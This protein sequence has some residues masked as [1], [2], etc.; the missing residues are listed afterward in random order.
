MNKTKENKGEMK[1]MRKRG[2]R[3]ESNTHTH[4]QYNLIKKKNNRNYPFRV[5][6]LCSRWVVLFMRLMNNEK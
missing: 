2:K 5:L 3:W 4:T 6:L 1:K